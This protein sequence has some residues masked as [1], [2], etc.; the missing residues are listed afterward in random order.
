MKVTTR[1]FP[2]KVNSLEGVPVGR[3]ERP[4]SSARSDSASAA[5]LLLLAFHAS[6]AVWMAT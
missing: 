4:S 2:M 5:L 3:R 1:S 6:R